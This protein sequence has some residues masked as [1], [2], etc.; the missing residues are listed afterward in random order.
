METNQW[1]SIKLS[2]SKS[3]VAV[4]K[5]QANQKSLVSFTIKTTEIVQTEIPF[6]GIEQRQ[7]YKISKFP[8][9]ICHIQILLFIFLIV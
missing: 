6:Y 5:N 9:F 4:K 3:T 2:K 1:Y 8:L 7:N